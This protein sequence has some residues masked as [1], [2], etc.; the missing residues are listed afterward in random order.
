MK[1]S[2]IFV[3]FSLLNTNKANKITLY[4]YDESSEV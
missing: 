3:H 4:S 1:S 2:K